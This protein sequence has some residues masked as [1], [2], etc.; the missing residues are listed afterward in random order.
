MAFYLFIQA[1]PESESLVQQRLSY[2]LRLAYSLFSSYVCL[3]D[4]LRS[5]YEG[6]KTFDNKIWTYQALHVGPLHSETSF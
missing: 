4:F 3:F 1:I 5:T 6:R 2:Q